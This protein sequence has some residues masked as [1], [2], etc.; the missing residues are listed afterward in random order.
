V[1]QDN[2]NTG[3]F[4]GAPKG[5]TA[6]EYAVG[7]KYLEDLAEYTGGR[8]FRA[9]ATSGGLTRAF[10]GIA[11]ELRRQYNIGYIPEDA[12][13]ARQ[14]ETIKVRVHRPDRPIRAR[15]SYMA[16]ETRDTADDAQ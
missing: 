9:E 12:G 16:G 11:E 7:K 14:R 5:T 1:Q 3:I 6:G 2:R 8:V 15:D 10:A 13:F 4:G